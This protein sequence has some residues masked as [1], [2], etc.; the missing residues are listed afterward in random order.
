MSTVP[1]HALANGGYSISQW[2]CLPEK[3][4]P[5]LQLTTDNAGIPCPAG[6]TLI[7]VPEREND[8]A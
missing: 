1:M 2:L 5:E 3:S 8:G 7:V 4:L 6:Y